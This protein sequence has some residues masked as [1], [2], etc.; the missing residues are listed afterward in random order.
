MLRLAL[1][2]AG[3]VAQHYL[4]VHD[5]YLLKRFLQV[6]AVVDPNSAM[7][8]SLAEKFSAIV[9]PDIAAI[10]PQVADLALV[11]TPSGMHEA[12]SR[13]LLQQGMPVLSEKPL[14][15]SIEAV[16]DNARLADMKGLAYGGVFQNRFNP[17]MKFA[18]QVVST[19]RLGKIV[20]ASV[21]LRW[22]RYQPYYQ[23]GWHGT[24]KLDGGVSNQQ[25][26]H[27][28]DALQWLCGM[29][30]ELAAFKGRQ[31]NILEA[32]DTLVASGITERGIFFTF[33]ATTAA[34]PEDFEASLS[35][36]GE[37]GYLDVGGVALN[38]IRRCLLIGEEDH[39]AEYCQR[40]SMAV[41]SGY[42][43]GHAD[44]LRSIAERFMAIGKIELPLSPEESLNAVRFV[45]ALYR[46]TEDGQIIQFDGNVRSRFLGV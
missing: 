42:G 17:A 15:L 28:V 16:L 22:C 9:L 11:L 27:H 18:H 35:L 23:D 44:L 46:A 3:R 1:V 7:A 45:H 43:I 40:H 37:K 41:T 31:A 38:E 30:R 12:H 19:G 33:E 36:V 20:S 8:N 32:E 2:G 24:W 6:T 10:T 26:I 25:A 21:R 14:G 4:H 5:E 39:E 29:P 13:Q 34:R